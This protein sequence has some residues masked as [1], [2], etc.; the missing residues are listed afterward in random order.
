MKQKRLTRNIEI[1]LA[2]WF[3]DTQL[4]CR[5]L[6]LAGH[7]N[8]VGDQLTTW[9]RFRILTVVDDFTKE[10]LATVPDTPITGQRLVAEVD[11]LIERRARP[12][13]IASDNGGGMTSR[14]VS[15]SAM[16]TGIDWHCIAP[17][18]LT[19][20]A[21]I[22]SFNSKRRDECLNENP[23]GSLADAVEKIGA[24]RF[25]YNTARPHSSIGNQTP[26]AF[27]AASVLA[28][29]RGETLRCPRG[30]APRPVASTTQTGSNTEQALHSNG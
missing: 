17:G 28:M 12:L 18:K 14:V 16:D 22:E 21:F 4:G 24:W 3:V 13:S 1:T 6:G 10:S 9:R 19:Q 30:F 15:Q 29:Q 2:C 20:S 8:F 7:R 25:D 26:A 11:K 27:A 5:C 23:F